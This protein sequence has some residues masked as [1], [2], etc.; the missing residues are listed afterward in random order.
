[1][2]M[3]GSIECMHDTAFQKEEASDAESDLNRVKL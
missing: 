1:M 2:E 3:E